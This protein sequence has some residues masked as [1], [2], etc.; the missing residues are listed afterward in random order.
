MDSALPTLVL[1]PFDLETLSSYSCSD[2]R[3]LR[4]VLCCGTIPACEPSQAV[5]V[6]MA[7]SPISCFHPSWWRVAQ[8]SGAVTA[9]T[10]S[11]AHKACTP[12]AAELFSVDCFPKSSKLCQLGELKSIEVLLPSLCRVTEGVP[13]RQHGKL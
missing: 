2:A 5:P 8:G 9:G 3:H 1:G 11:R 7:P 4:F 13:V 10:A 12:A 6:P